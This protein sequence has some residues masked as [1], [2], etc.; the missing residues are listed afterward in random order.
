MDERPEQPPEGRLLA[1]A[2]ERSGMSIR[3][4]SKKAGLSYG[5]WRQI[6]SGF[7]NVSPGS[8]AA[9][10]GPAPTVARMARVVGVT[11]DQMAEAGREDAAAVMRENARHL[12]AVSSGSSEFDVA[13]RT[14]RDLPLP[15][16][17]KEGMIAL[18][19]GMRQQ[20][21]ESTNGGRRTGT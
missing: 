7:Q 5:R 21:E 3:Q 1:Q 14:I 20:E 15:D 10:R 9:V 18:A 4:A 19:L 13:V 6:T 12:S 8:W 2:L 16:N 11:P 17:V